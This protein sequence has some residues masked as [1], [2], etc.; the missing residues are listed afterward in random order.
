ML[1]EKVCIQID[2]PIGTHC[3][4]CGCASPLNFGHIVQPSPFHGQ[5]AY[6]LG[7]YEP[8]QQ[9]E[10]HIIGRVE[11]PHQ[12][13]YVW[14]VAPLG[15]IFYACDI[16]AAVHYQEATYGSSLLPLYDKSC[17]GILLYETSDGPRVLL[18]RSRQNAYWGFPKGHMEEGES[19]QDTA[20]REILEETGLSV[21]FEPTFRGSISLVLP[22][23]TQKELVF[24]LAY[25]HSMEVRLSC[26]H[27]DYRWLRPEEAASQLTFANDR[28]I[29]LQAMKQFHNQ[30]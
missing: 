25:C 5:Q 21:S 20:Y 16:R 18:I 9:M 17:G 1:G 2:Q 26:E 3:A 22:E 23:G 14:V 19:E 11:R 6:A 24:F 4:A 10:G 30:L 28:H 13:E 15:R 27:T 29:F 8:I 7:I 12:A